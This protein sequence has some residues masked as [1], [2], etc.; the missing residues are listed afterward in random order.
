M[1]TTKSD[2]KEYTIQLTVVTR[3]YAPYLSPLEFIRKKEIQSVLECYKKHEN[4][5]ED[6]LEV[7]SHLDRAFRRDFFCRPYVPMS[8]LSG[9]LR[10]VSPE[11]VVRG[12]VLILPREHVLVESKITPHYRMTAEYLEPTM[13][14]FNAVARLP[15][16]LE[17]KPLQIRM[18]GGAAKGFGSAI[19]VF[20]PE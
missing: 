7:L 16:E 3:L 12:E 11:I 19:V 13:L 6:D 1:P 17:G 8:M 10:E 14:E 9:A 18:G 2:F 5:T 4:P 15:K 20:K